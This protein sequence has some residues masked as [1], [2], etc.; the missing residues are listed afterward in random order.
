MAA[1]VNNLQLLLAQYHAR[2]REQFH[3]KCFAVGYIAGGGIEHGG[4][5]PN[6]L[7]L[8]VGGVVEMQVHLLLRAQAVEV[9]DVCALHE[10]SLSLLL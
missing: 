1:A 10:D 9:V 8:E 3:V 2:G 6:G 5:E 4:A 7:A